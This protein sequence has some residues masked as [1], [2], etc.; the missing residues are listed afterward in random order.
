LGRC[1]QQPQLKFNVKGKKRKKNLINKC[2]ISK[3]YNYQNKDHS[4]LKVKCMEL[5]GVSKDGVTDPDEIQGGFRKKQ[6]LTGGWIGRWGGSA[7]EI[8]A[9]RSLTLVLEIAI[10]SIIAVSF[11]CVGL[12]TRPILKDWTTICS[13]ST[14]I[15]YCS[16]VSNIT[17][18]VFT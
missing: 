18:P 5:Y 1:S 3:A 7:S 4:I 13:I 17:P 2:P 12:E 15:I 14:S 11:H 16:L 10:S 6:Y 8:A 9:I